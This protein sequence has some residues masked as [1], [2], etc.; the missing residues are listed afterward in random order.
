MSVCR[1]VYCAVTL[2]NRK[3]YYYRGVNHE[4]WTGDITRAKFFISVGSDEPKKALAVLRDITGAVDI[5][6]KFVELQP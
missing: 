4:T 3:A 1:F 2:P 5:E 6:H